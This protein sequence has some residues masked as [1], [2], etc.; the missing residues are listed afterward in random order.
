MSDN[1]VKACPFCGR[2]ATVIYVG[3]SGTTSFYKV[4]CQTSRCYGHQYTYGASPFTS[5]EEAVRAWNRRKG[6]EF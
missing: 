2:K 6:E 5:K 1:K 3:S 4:T